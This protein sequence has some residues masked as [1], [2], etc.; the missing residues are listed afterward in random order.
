MSPVNATLPLL[1]ND[2]VARGIFSLHFRSP[3]LAAELRP[4]QFLNIL[5]SDQYDP[6]LRRPF[7]ICSV[8]GDDCEILYAVVGKGTGL[9]ARM[10]PG[11]AIGVL[12]PLGNGFNCE[13]PLATALLVAGG[14]GVAP[15]PFL[16]RR[17]RARG[18]RVD[19]F[20][21][22]RDASQLVTAGLPSP[23]LATDDGSAGRPGT[24]VALL[25]EYLD[26]GAPSDPAIFACGPLP[27]LR[28]VRE[29]A[30]RRSI[31][32]ELSLESE[33]A[34]GMGICQGCPVRRA[35][36]DDRYALVCTDGPCFDAR[37]VLL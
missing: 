8:H 15:F 10:R 19:S 22:A 31:P 26:A 32:C 35:G 23:R 1:S 11:D 21:G 18:A 13:R 14:I 6:L 5:V 28:A 4:G 2:E 27:M 20:V 37:E 24:V 30:L 25:E 36:S 29:L 12:G 17:L 9:L 16:A 3:E 33:M 7:S 34:C